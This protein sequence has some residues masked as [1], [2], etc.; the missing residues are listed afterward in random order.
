MIWKEEWRM[1]E[2]NEIKR[3]ACT[4]D[5]INFVEDPISEEY[6]RDMT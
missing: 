4:H 2:I 6:I 3:K 5:L 1:A